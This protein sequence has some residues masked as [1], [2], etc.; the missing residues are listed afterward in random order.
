MML[1]G[2][3]LAPFHNSPSPFLA[4]GVFVLFMLMMSVILLNA[5]IAIMSNTFER[6][7]DQRKA[8]GMLEKAKVILEIESLMRCTNDKSKQRKRCYQHFI[9]VFRMLLSLPILHYVPSRSVSNQVD[10]EASADRCA[11]FSWRSFCWC[12]SAEGASARGSKRAD[13]AQFLHVLMSEQTCSHAKSRVECEVCKGLSEYDQ[14]EEEERGPES[15]ASMEQVLSKLGQL[16]AAATRAAS[17]AEE[18]PMNTP[19]EGT[20]LGSHAGSEEGELTLSA[21]FVDELATWVTDDLKL[22]VPEAAAHHEEVKGVV[23]THVGGVVF[24]VKDGHLHHMR[25][26]SPTASPRTSGRQSAQKHHRQSPR[27]DGELHR[28]SSRAGGVVS[29]GPHPT[30]SISFEIEVARSEFAKYADGAKEMDK[31]ELNDWAE[32]LAECV[33]VGDDEEVRSTVKYIV[34]ERGNESL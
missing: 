24:S 29:G 21:A 18:L 11:A 6:V 12:V 13:R 25:Q 22:A 1:G 20:A 15:V 19:G 27:D 8:V 30:R 10:D 4:V 32:T 33:Q 17:S 3:D 9:D 26:H 5:V 14:P 23:T 16:Q 34:D 28:I 7:N 2:F 31:Q